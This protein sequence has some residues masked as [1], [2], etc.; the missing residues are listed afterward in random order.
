MENDA[1][2]INGKH[3]RTGRDGREPA[4]T[5]GLVGCDRCPAYKTLLMTLSQP[6]FNIFNTTIEHLIRVLLDH[7]AHI[8]QPNAAGK[9]PREAIVEISKHSSSEIHILNYM[10]LKCFCAAI[11]SKYKIPYRNQIP[12]TLENFVK[13]HEP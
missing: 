4:A 6:N 9:T 13:L 2:G 3:D 5:I 7:G 10:S 8:D 1:N 11:I 12:K